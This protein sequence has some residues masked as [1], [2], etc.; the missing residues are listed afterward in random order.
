M[1]YE[2]LPPTSDLFGQVLA[3]TMLAVFVAVLFGRRRLSRTDLLLA[4]WEVCLR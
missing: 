2:W 1:S 3:V 4:V